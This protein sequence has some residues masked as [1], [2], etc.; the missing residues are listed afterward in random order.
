MSISISAITIAIGMLLNMNM[1]MAAD[2]IRNL[3]LHR[4]THLSGD[5]TRVLDWLL[6]ALPVLLGM[7]LGTGGITWLSLTLTITITSVTVSNNLRIV[8]NNGGAVMDLLVN[9]F[10]VLSDNVLAFLDVGGVNYDIVLLMTGLVILDVVLCVAVLLLV[11]I[12]IVAS[13][14]STLSNSDE[15]KSSDES[16]HLERDYPFCI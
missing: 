1:R 8:T 10:T 7:A 11:S 5:L 6:V 15:S 9:F 12:S 14:R 2:L 16:E 4:D 3:D 13:S